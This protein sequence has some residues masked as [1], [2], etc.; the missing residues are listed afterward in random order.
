LTPP[1]Y[2]LNLLL[3]LQDYL[4]SN[5]ILENPR[6]GVGI[7]ISPMP[8]APWPNVGSTFA[9]AGKRTALES[10][11][12]NRITETVIGK[13]LSSGERTQ[14]RAGVKHKNRLNDRPHPGPLL[15]GEGET[16]AVPLKICVSFG[17]AASRQSAAI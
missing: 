6:A 4:T 11:T 5:S 10:R 1:N 9:P 13:I 7:D 17:V 15:Q 12:V 3:K 2:H 14:V 8:A 16:F